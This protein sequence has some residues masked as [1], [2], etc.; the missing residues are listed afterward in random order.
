[1]PRHRRQPAADQLGEG[2]LAVAVRPEKP[3]PV[4]V[5]EGEVDARQHDPVAIAGADLLHRDDRRAE[6]LGDRRPF[7][8]Q[9]GLVDHRRDRLH[10]GQHLEARLGLGRL[11]RAGAE[12]VDEGLQVGAPLLLLLQ[13]LAL[14]RLLLAALALEAGVAAGPK[15]ELA[16][17]EM[18]DVVG[19]VVE[20]VAVV[21]DDDDRR[22]AGSSGSR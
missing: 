11:G 5:G 8:R 6:L 3:D 1:M 7:E 14:K 19:D 4:V 10:P 2:R 22:G 21:A 12:T 15:R 18:Q 13:R 20:Q 16:A 9:D 17:V